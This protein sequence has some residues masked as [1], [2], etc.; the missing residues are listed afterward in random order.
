MLAR[1]LRQKFVR[2]DSDR[3]DQLQFIAN[4]A[5]DHFPHLHRAAVQPLAAARIQKRLVQRK[6]LHHRRVAVKNFANLRADF[7]VEFSARRQQN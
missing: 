2:R 3:R 7:G 6:R 4:V 1:Q 5:L